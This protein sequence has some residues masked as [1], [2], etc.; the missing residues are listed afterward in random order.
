MAPAT[1]KMHR[2]ARNVYHQLDL[3]EQVQVQE[4]LQA[5]VGLSP[6][7]WPGATDFSTPN[8]YP[9]YL[10]PIDNSLRFIIQAKEGQEPE[11]IDIIRQERLDAFAKYWAEKGK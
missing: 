5:L 2:R 10:V 11:V 4:K 3:D 9:D 7:Q 8:S 6:A 1:L